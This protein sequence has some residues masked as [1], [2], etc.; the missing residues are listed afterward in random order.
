MRCSSCRAEIISGANRCPYCGAIAK[1]ET[2]P[3]SDLP[4]TINVGQSESRGS[5]IYRDN[6]SSVFEI[7]AMNKNGVGGRGT[8]F[9]ISNNGLALTNVHV[10]TIDGKVS[11]I[12]SANVGGSI[13]RA[14]VVALGD[15]KGGQGEG[16]DVALIKLERVP[17]SVKCVRIGDSA[18]VI[19]GEQIFYIG[20]SLGEGLCITGGIVSD[21]CRRMGG[22]EFIMTDAATNP[23]NSGGPLFNDRGEVIGVHVSAHKDAVG[24]KYA[25]PINAVKK[26]FPGIIY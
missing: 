12:L 18:T 9:L 23:G 3:I 6:I 22:K 8:G 11:D 15:N 24:M 16:V 17:S 1:R 19:N 21:V 20:N 4:K 2:V 14:E 7:T 25:I 13:I 10:V 5:D 26:T